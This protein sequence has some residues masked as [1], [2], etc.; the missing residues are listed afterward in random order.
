MN[1]AT[2]AFPTLRVV[3]EAKERRTNVRYNPDPLVPVLFAHPTAA[4]PTAGL[5]ADISEGGVR[6]IA[7]PTA[8]PM[9]HWGDP[10][11]IAV[12][13]SEST[14]EAGVEGLR[15]WAHTVRIAVDREQY[16]LQAA[17]TSNGSQGDWDRLTQWIQ[18]MAKTYVRNR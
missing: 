7:P 9:L 5:I 1:P 8:R 18:S 4:N 15:L 2:T 13:Y 3:E 12:S 11:G 16:T 6:I 17:F 10:L 14:R